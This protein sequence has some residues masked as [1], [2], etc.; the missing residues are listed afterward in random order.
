MTVKRQ[1]KQTAN[2]NNQDEEFI[3]F[4]LSLGIVTSNLIMRSNAMAK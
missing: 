4:D 2:G 1:T 3:Y